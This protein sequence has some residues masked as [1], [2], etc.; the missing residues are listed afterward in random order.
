[1]TVRITPA[2]G[3]VRVS[4][5]VTGVPAGEHCRM[6]VVSKTGDREIAGSWVVGDDGK[7]GGK[8]AELEGSAAVKPGDVKAV[9]V[10]NDHGKKYV[11]VP[12]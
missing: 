4:A 1:M 8:G 3:W 2:V 9:V 7:G 6:V 11:T 5:A 10:E 12:V